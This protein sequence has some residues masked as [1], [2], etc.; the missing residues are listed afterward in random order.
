M[1]LKSRKLEL[2]S[3]T[4]EW[5]TLILYLG[6][7][8][9]PSSYVFDPC[10]HFYVKRK[11]AIKIHSSI[12]RIWASNFC[13]SAKLMS[14]I[15]II[16]HLK[17]KKQKMIKFPYNKHLNPLLIYRFRQTIPQAWLILAVTLREDG[18]T[19][20]G[21]YSVDG[22]FSH[23][24]LSCVVE[25]WPGLLSADYRS[26]PLLPANNWDKKN[27]L[28]LIVYLNKTGNLVYL[29]DEPTLSMTVSLIY[30]S[31]RKYEK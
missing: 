12:T 7:I 15:H 8:N 18:S 28:Y 31:F 17:K 13:S 1:R 24:R 3:R 9:I 4:F 10:I 23:G 6:I 25:T 29:I 20:T 11:T 21:E 27:L 26:T 2:S 22:V 14:P 5:S 16:V 30:H 19:D